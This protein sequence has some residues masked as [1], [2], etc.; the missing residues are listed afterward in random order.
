MTTA[1]VKLAVVF[2]NVLFDLASIGL[3]VAKSSLITFLMRL[4]PPHQSAVKWRVMII[5]PLAVLGVVSLGSMLA[6]WSRCFSELGG[7]T[8]LCSS[9]TPAMHWMQVT[10]AF[11]VA[12][13]LWYAAMP[14][15][16]LRRLTRPR[17]EKMLVQGSMSLGVIAAGCGIARAL[18]I[19]PAVNNSEASSG[20]FFFYLDFS[21]YSADSSKPKIRNLTSPQKKKSAA[22]LYMWHGAEMAVTM[23]CIGMPVC[24][25]AVSSMLHA[26]GL[27]PRKHTVS[28]S[29]DLNNSNNNHQHKPSSYIR[30]F[31]GGTWEEAVGGTDIDS[32]SQR[33]ILGVGD[34]TSNATSMSTMTSSSMNSTTK[35]LEAGGFGH[36]GNG[37]GGGGGFDVYPMTALS[38]TGIT[39]TKTVDITKD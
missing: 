32:W 26:C 2:E 30:N 8:L 12:I 16:L 5:G 21:C 10:A 1:D 3:I 28:S 23:I 39:V 14:W 34:A 36:G 35:E 22:I 37:G 9:I 38:K 6:M 31:G 7:Q 25:P 20:T 27:V 11:S 29:K 4:V 17:R 18:T 19:Y 33:R 13:D 24:R 15:Y